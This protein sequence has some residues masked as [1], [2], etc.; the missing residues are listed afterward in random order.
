MREY[1]TLSTLTEAVATTLSVRF[2][3]SVWVTAEIASLR[4]H[5]SGHCYI[6]LV[7]TDEK[8]HKEL[9]R[10][11]ATIWKGRY[12]LL[13]AYFYSATQTPLQ[14]G[15]RVLLEA[16]VSYHP[17]YGLSLNITDVDPSYTLGAVEQARRQ[18]IARL[19]AEGVFDMNRTLS[20]PELPRRIAVIS[21]IG[22]AGLGDFQAHLKE[23]IARFG[24]RVELFE[25]RMQGATAAQSV[26][27]ALERVA[28]SLDS[29]DIVVILRGG[30]SLLDLACFD[31]YALAAH[32]AQFPLPVISGIGHE[33]DV[34]VVDLVAH[35]SLK[36]P[37]AVADF[38]GE[39]FFGAERDLQALSQR[40][41]AT[42]TQQAMRHANALQVT[43]SLV[44]S[45]I[46]GQLNAQ[47][48]ALAPLPPSLVRGVRWHIALQRRQL[49][50]RV[51]ALRQATRY[52]LAQQEGQLRLAQE[53]HQLGNPLRLLDAGYVMVYQSGQRVRRMA[54][55]AMEQPLDLQFHDGR[56][57]VEVAGGATTLPPEQFVAWP[58]GGA[59]IDVRSPSE[60]RQGHVP[61]A[62]NVPLF[63]DAARAEVGTLYHKQGRSV[64][65]ARGMELV[66][67]R[68]STLYSECCRVAEGKSLRMYCWRGGMRSAS[69]AW[70]AGRD[71]L[72]V[73]LLEGGYKAYR[74]LVLE[75]FV[76]PRQL[77]ILGGMTGSGKSEVLHEM[78]LQGAA[79]IDLSLIHIS[80]PTRQYS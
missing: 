57:Q 44:R 56:L 70:L 39:I 20:F 68:L 5:V 50:E 7:E 24:L 65:I 60:F 17:V 1:I 30:G 54:D 43:T 27:S 33:R 23:A 73:Y 41:R 9:A 3:H 66:G 13:K 11:R 42:I 78:A 48:Q 55:V 31:D 63:D 37:T 32:V 53:V 67:P 29:W 49:E 2:S 16:K 79:V 36:T 38:L 14:E 58:E 12:G 26:I 10:M 64:A 34:S 6:E 47:R 15:L 62:V 46:G 76:Q 51:S 45:A 74:R 52:A 75:S 18:T 40:L 71:G 35:Y 69:M 25:A 59:I 21:A 28:D 72:K 19:Q 22:A 80:E 8:T 77:A 61:G 4:E